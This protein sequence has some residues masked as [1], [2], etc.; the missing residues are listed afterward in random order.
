MSALNLQQHSTG[1]D[2]DRYAE[3]NYKYYCTVT[4]FEE[5]EADVRRTEQC[6]NMFFCQGRG[7]VSKQ[8]V[9]NRVKYTR[10]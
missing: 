6:G 10:R 9:W 3:L 8:L 5:H 4:A 2:G 1:C 7:T